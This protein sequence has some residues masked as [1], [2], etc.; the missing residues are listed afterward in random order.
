MINTIDLKNNVITWECFECAKVAWIF[1]QDINGIYIVHCE[2]CGLRHELS[3][4]KDDCI[5]ICISK[6]SFKYTST[7]SCQICKQKHYIKGN[8]VN[9]KTYSLEKLNNDNVTL[10]NFSSNNFSG[11]SH[12][13]NHLFFNG[14]CYGVI[15]AYSDKNI[16]ESQNNLNKLFAYINYKSICQTKEIEKLKQQN[17]EISQKFDTLLSKVSNLLD[18]IEYS[19]DNGPAMI[20]AKERFKQNI[21]NNDK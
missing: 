14:E 7:M 13:G 15:E 21:Q 10:V 18:M 3:K 19:P 8:Y 20:E 11:V 5:G 4:C 16:S 6:D 17:Q 2:N 1:I 9:G 12:I